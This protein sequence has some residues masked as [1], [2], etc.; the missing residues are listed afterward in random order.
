MRQAKVYAILLIVAVVALIGM[1][2]LW[3][4]KDAELTK[5]KQISQTRQG[6]ADA[7]KKRATEYNVQLKQLRELVAGSERAEA[8]PDADNKFVRDQLDAVTSFMNDKFRALDN[9]R[10]PKKYE[11]LLGSVNPIDDLKDFLTKVLDSRQK[12]RDLQDAAEKNT[13]DLQK[14]HKAETEKKEEVASGLKDE[15]AKTQES[16]EKRLTEKTQENERLQKELATI[17]NDVATNDIKGA[18]LLGAKDSQIGSLLTRLQQVQEEQ[19][20]TRGIEDVEPDG[21]LINVLSSSQLGW[22]NVGRKHHLRPGLEFQVFQAV[23]GSKRQ[24]KGKI[25]VRKVDEDVS[26]VRIVDTTD[27]LNPIAEGDYITSPF[28]DPKATP[29]FVIAGAGLESRSITEEALRQKIL[30]Y[31]ATIAPQV[32]LKTSFVI[33]LK[34]Y[35]EKP[36]YKQAREL[37]VPILRESE[38]LKYMGL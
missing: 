26:E 34:G 31:G 29:T 4:M 15:I 19:T 7:E 11:T 9:N 12:A 25:E 3:F 14:L 32:D 20:K 5:E 36:Q 21:R 2:I 6:V 24:Y 38:I 22:I 33:A 13:A 16:Y 37:G 17:K 35:E 10:A 8:W 28:Y 30:S 1:S 27:E 18:R 23:K